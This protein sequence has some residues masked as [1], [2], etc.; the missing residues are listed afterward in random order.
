MASKSSY[1]NYLPPVLWEK[2]PPPPQF[3]LST[4]LRIFEKIL[5]GIDDAESVQ[6]GTHTHPGIEETIAKLARLFAP[7]TT[8]PEFLPWLAQWVA[9]QYP[10]AWDEYQR[11]KILSEI[12]PIY[13][14]RGIKDG[15]DDFLDIYGISAR[16]PRVVV[17][18]ANKVLFVD[19]ARGAARPIYTLVSQ[20]PLV[21][22]HSIDVGADGSFFVTDLGNNVGPNQVKPAVWRLSSTGQYDFAGPIA[23]AQPLGPPAF[24]PNAP[25]A[26]IADHAVQF[27]IYVLD[28]GLT[29][30][31]YYLTSPAFADPAPL[32]ANALQL[33]VVWGIA[34]ALDQNGDVLILDRGALPAA[35]SVTKI[36][37]SKF[38]GAP[39]VFQN[40]TDHALPGIVE[41]LSIVVR[42][43]GN[44]IVGDAKDQANPV[45]A[46]LVLVDRTNPG[47]V[48]ASLL[49][50]TNAG[51]TIDVMR[52]GGAN[53][54]QMRVTA[55]QL[56]V[57]ALNRPGVVVDGANANVVAGA[58][59]NEGDVLVFDGHNRLTVA[60]NGGTGHVIIGHKEV[61]G[62][63]RML[64]GREGGDRLRLEAATGA[65]VVERIDAINGANVEVTSN[66]SIDGILRAKGD[67]LMG[68]PRGRWPQCGWNPIPA[69]PINMTW[70]SDFRGNAR[71]TR[72]S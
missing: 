67:I 47:W 4:M 1:I 18:D 3:S 61:P 55:N 49:G 8:R 33:A 7:W 11:R 26:V 9:L 57:G 52:G 65:A 66:L 27:G 70:I 29:Y 35:P 10:D 50:A 41:P 64:G 6:H 37:D 42:Q 51:D 38:L 72:R 19:T 69:P 71:R 40:K 30:V 54:A 45:P 63:L 17:D 58:M 20:E 5:T 68:T 16:K 21:A 31:L 28:A 48:T 43:D 53:F 39:P 2:D 12:V 46:D 32:V 34:L 15:L 62:Q 23:H 13:V 14:R 56:N 44:L 36:V 59:N 60:L 25:I 22:P 24:N